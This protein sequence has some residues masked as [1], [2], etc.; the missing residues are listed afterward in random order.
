MDSLPY[1]NF[2]ALKELA[3]ESDGVASSCT[4]TKQSL[5]EWTS[6]PV[7]FPEPQLERIGTLIQ[8]DAD[9]AT[10]A[11]YH[12]DG[13]SF[14]SAQAPI[15]PLHYPYNRCD[16]W[17]CRTCGR[18][19]LRYTE[20]GGYFVDQRIRQLTAPLLVDAPLEDS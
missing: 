4:C 16:M 17:K 2:T 6:L 10:F 9:Q 7:S 14:W 8:G 20:G 11:E 19:Y 3:L 15:A 18:V 13:S 5:V 1:L 12:P